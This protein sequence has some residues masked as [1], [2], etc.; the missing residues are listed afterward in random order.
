[1]KINEYRKKGCDKDGNPFKLKLYPPLKNVVE[2]VH[3]A[4]GG[5]ILVK[6]NALLK[7][8]N[9]RLLTTLALQGVQPFEHMHKKEETP[10]LE[11]HDKVQKEFVVVHKKCCTK[12]GGQ[13][14]KQVLKP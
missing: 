6:A 2:G 5:N 10:P 1:M 3:L 13:P 8:N 4:K 11:I 9:I 14:V 7:L 12:H